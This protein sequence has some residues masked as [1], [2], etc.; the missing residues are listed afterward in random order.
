[1]VAIHDVA[2][3]WH[4]LLVRA[5]RAAPRHDGLGGKMVAR[6]KS[7][8]QVVSPR[9]NVRIASPLR[10]FLPPVASAQSNLAK[11]SIG[12]LQDLCLQ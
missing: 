4:R 2:Q 12:T 6:A 5:H 8:F 3:R 7:A 10:V 1:M 11:H 9:Q